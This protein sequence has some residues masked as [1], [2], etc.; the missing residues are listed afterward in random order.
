MKK[1]KKPW[2]NRR[3]F[4]TFVCIFLVL[5]LFVSDQVSICDATSLSVIKG[6][7][8]EEKESID[9]AFI[10][11]SEFYAGYSPTLAWEKYGYTSYALAC[12]SV[13]GNLYKSMLT[14]VLKR[15]SPKLVVFE[16]NAFLQ[17]DSYYEKPAKLHTWIDNLP[18][19]KNKI[20]TIQE[21]IPEEE[22]Y[23]YYFKLAAN[24]N[25]WN[26]PKRWAGNKWTELDLA[27]KGRSY[28][29][30]FSTFTA[31][32]DESD[33]KKYNPR[34]T[35]KGR[36]YLEDLL[37]YCKQENV[38]QVLFVRF[39]HAREF[40]KMDAIYEIQGIVESYG[41]DFLN[42]NNSYEEIGIDLHKDFYNKEHLNVYGMEKMTNYMGNYIIE[43]YSVKSEH[44]QEQA[45]H[46]DECA[47][48]MQ[49]VIKE[50]KN[51]IEA[52]NVKHYWEVS[53]K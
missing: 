22:R 6:F 13:P 30:G 47:E 12:G 53:I 48:K 27:R 43:N 3:R 29:K 2:S 32:K 19:S 46:W 24:H 36:A 52:G 39:P 9:V 23:S 17:K 10:G 25:N 21:L 49:K 31:S 37:E 15:Q 20:E 50:C 7:Y 34:L 33:G 18:W 1:E 26:S 44:T 4:I 28:G 38:E 11:P 51:D 16:I 14:E 45:Q 40:K 42:L 8:K 5:F 41:Y 35:E